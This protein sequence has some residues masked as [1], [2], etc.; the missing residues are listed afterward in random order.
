MAPDEIYWYRI[1]LFVGM[2][3]SSMV[4]MSVTMLVKSDSGCRIVIIVIERYGSLKDT[5][6]ALG[7]EDLYSQGD[8][9]ALMILRPT[10]Q[11]YLKSLLMISL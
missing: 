8:S 7:R 1:V 5:L 3:V 9:G 11:H 4:F 2:T 6:K 10:S